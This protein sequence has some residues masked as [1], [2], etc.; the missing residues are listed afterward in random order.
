MGAVE[1]VDIDCV[2]VMDGGIN[3]RVRGAHGTDGGLASVGLD[4]QD[5]LQRAVGS[6]DAEGRQKSPELPSP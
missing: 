3:Q 4:I 5:V 2:V 1:G 6:G